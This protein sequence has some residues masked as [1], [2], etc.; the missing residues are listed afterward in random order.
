LLHRVGGRGMV[1][2][3]DISTTM[4]TRAR[5]RFRRERAA[6]LLRLHDGSITALPMAD[7]SVDAAITINTLYFVAELDEALGE[8]ARVLAPA[9]RAVLGVGDPVTMA[10][11][12]V[13]RHGF[14]LRPVAELE[15]ALAAAG[16]VV[17]R[18]SR[19]GAGDSAFH[20][21]IARSHP[22]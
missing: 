21:L 6:G 10:G 4:L 11:A 8:L 17:E 3:F 9:G 22:G 1:H 18:H 14:R 7:G 12:G 5:R 2:G 16:L 19:V 20:L 15:A 13:T